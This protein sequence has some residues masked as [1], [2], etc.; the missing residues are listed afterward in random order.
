[1]RIRR[2]RLEDG[3]TIIAFNIA[4]AMET[5]S[6]ALDPSLITPGVRAVLGDK[7]KGLYFVGE[8][9]G[10]VVGQM[11]V[12]FEWSDWRNG[13]IWWIQSV[14]VDPSHRRKGVFKSLYEHVRDEAR[15]NRVVAL[16]LYVEREN[17][18]AQKTYVTMG[19]H[20]SHYLLMEEAL[21]SSEEHGS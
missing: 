7:T 21:A 2:G 6:L 4:M 15:K 3:N 9:D 18:N 12:T 16:R 19:M 13:N 5:E 10:Q 20:L 11:M 1:M 8:V 17:E 14:Y